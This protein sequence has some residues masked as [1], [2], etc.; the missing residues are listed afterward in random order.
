MEGKELRVTKKL[1]QDLA[2][3]EERIGLMKDLFKL[4]VGFQ[5]D[6]D[7]NIGLLSK[8]R[9]EKMREKGEKMTRKM[10][11][12]AMEIK[13]RDEEFYHEEKKIERDQRRRDIG[14]KLVKNSRH[15]RENIESIQFARIR[16]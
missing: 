12:S 14:E 11:R 4:N 10:V 7:F 3:S 16:G 8:L 9:S 1:W 2:S 15:Y 13:I 6:E 5:E